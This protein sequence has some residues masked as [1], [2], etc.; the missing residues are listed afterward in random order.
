MTRGIILRERRREWVCN[1]RGRWRSFLQETVRLCHKAKRRLRYCLQPLD[2]RKVPHSTARTTDFTKK[3]TMR[4]CNATR[5]AI[6]SKYYLIL[7]MALHDSPLS[8]QPLHAN[9]SSQ[10][11]T[12]K[13]IHSTL[14][15]S[16]SPY[17][18]RRQ[19]RQPSPHSS[20]RQRSPSTAPLLDV[21]TTRRSSVWLT[22]LVATEIRLTEVSGR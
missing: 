15:K 18:Q 6:N 7:L 3:A 17:S 1:R 9:N 4:Y 10:S 20:Y 12:K 14:P 11:S 5:V 21:S 19:H 22:E 13:P 8:F 16:P 2:Y